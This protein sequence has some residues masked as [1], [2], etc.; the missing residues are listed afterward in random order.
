M[1]L[2]SMQKKKMCKVLIFKGVLFIDRMGAYDP[3]LGQTHPRWFSNQDSGGAREMITEEVRNPE[4][5]KRQARSAG[6]GTQ[7]AWNRWE[8]AVARKLPWPSFFTMDPLRLSFAIR[9]TYDL[10]QTPANLKQWSLTNDDICAICKTHRA[11]NGSLQ[12]YT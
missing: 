3:V 2:P 8:A 11:C 10:L 1:A 6:S 7:C 12:K 5:Q 4:E 9:S